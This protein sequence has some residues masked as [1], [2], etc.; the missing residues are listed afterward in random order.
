MNQNYTLLQNYDEILR[1]F[2]TWLNI[3]KTILLEFTY[4]PTQEWV[5]ISDETRTIYTFNLGLEEVAGVPYMKTI[6]I[7]SFYHVLVQ[8]VQTKDEVKKIKDSFGDDGMR[9]IDI[10][11]DFYTAKFLHSVYHFTIEDFYSTIYDGSST[12]K[13][14]EARIGKFNR[15]IGTMLT[16]YNYFINGSKILYHPKLVELSPKIFLYMLKENIRV[17]TIELSES[18]IKQLKRLYHKPYLFKKEEYVKLCKVFSELI[19][20]KVEQ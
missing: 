9:T 18:D 13:D 20:N 1:D 19:L 4:E 6:L 7:H 12:F 5:V 14:T 17:Q 16:V 8:N 11:A 10:E 2:I 15:F 3:K